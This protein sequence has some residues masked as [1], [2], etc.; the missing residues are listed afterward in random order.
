MICLVSI[1]KASKIAP[2]A[3]HVDN[4]ARSQIVTKD[5][6]VDFHD[7]IKKFGKKKSGYNK[8]KYCVKFSHGFYLFQNSS[9]KHRTTS[10]L[11]DLFNTCT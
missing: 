8:Y 6:N 10:M 3:C 4:T 7:L 11:T 5:F 9:G 2:A 1:L